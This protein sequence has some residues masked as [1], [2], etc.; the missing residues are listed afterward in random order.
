VATVVAGLTMSLDG[1]IAHRDD[2]VQYLFDWYDNGEVEVQWPGNDMVSHVS[3]AS[4]AYL[5][6]L[7]DGAGALVVGRRVFDYTNGWGGSHPIGVPVFLVTHSTPADWPRVDAPFTIVLDGVESAI[8]QAKSVAGNKS[9]GVAG[10]NVIQQCLNLGLIDELHVELV[11]VLLGDGIRFFG[12]LAHPPV[13]LDD[14]TVIEGKHVTHL[15]YKVRRDG[16]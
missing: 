9:V 4:A 5:H 7:I 10:P 14:P 3:P 2:S 16:N 6:E 15:T 1:F 11:P 12:E 8:A 13:V